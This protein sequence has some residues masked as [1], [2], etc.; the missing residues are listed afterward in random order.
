M[1]ICVIPIMHLLKTQNDVMVSAQDHVL[2]PGYTSPAIRAFDVVR[3]VKGGSAHILVIS[4]D[5]SQL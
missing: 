2:P 3:L 4:Y 1:S 5:I